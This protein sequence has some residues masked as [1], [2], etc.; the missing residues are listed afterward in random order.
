MAI[1]PKKDS[2]NIKKMSN[3]Y[4]EYAPAALGLAF[5]ADQLDLMAVNGVRVK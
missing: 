3:Q 2:K 5:L 1:M 4:L